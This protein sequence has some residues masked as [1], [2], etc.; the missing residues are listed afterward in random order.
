MKSSH[1]FPLVCIGI[2]MMCPFSTG[3]LCSSQKTEGA[4]QPALQQNK[5]AASFES[6]SFKTI[7]GDIAARVTPSIVS[8]ILTKIDTM[9]FNQ[10]PFFNFFGNDDSLDENP[11]NFFFGEP[12]SNHRHG[13]SKN[14]R[15]EK[16]E[17]REQ[18]IGSGVIVSQD[19]YILTNYH[20][21]SGASEIQVKLFDERSYEA[22]I[23]GADSLSDVAV[24]KIKEKV[25]NLPVATLGDDVKMRPGD[26][27]L[28]IGNPFSLTSTVTLG[29][30]SALH[31]E[32]D[33]NP[34]LY[35]NFIQTD[36]AI[37]PGN[38]GGA[39]VNIDGEVV[40]INTMIYSQTGGF[41]G[42][43]FA[44]PISMAK[45]V[46]DAILTKGKVVRGWIGISI[47]DLNEV[48][49]TTLNV[50]SR[51]GVLISDVFKGQPADKAG[52]K[53]GDVI[54]AIAGKNIENA[55]QLRNYVAELKPGSK[56]P[57]ALLRNGKEVV[58]QLTVEE[59]TEKVVSASG[60]EG[61]GQPGTREGSDKSE[62]RFGLTLSDLTQSLRSKYDL[63]DNV[64]GVLIIAVDRSLGDVRASL[65]EGDV[66]EQ[67][68]VRDKDYQTVESVRQFDEI[69]K[70]V[71]KGDSMLLVVVRKSASL[72]IGF[73]VH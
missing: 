58:L 62:A 53:R 34:N 11:F 65:R 71:K 61:E 23:V 72:F 67:V 1:L 57:A 38:S 12:F 42:I 24:L 35:Q 73:V 37:N 2:I 56:V 33:G 4:P 16:R 52:I 68:K 40:G 28:A 18:G 59:R 49:K 25:Q 7:F 13:M 70:T 48:M 27:A 8:V 55:N 19:G 54:T 69:A 36:A 30:V 10:N 50:G 3:L 5:Q 47:Q 64:K 31:R 32:V 66:I 63:A 43:G 44:I 6:P 45:T 9:T 46:M 60:K 22:K 14:P 26:W 29:I 20:V 15:P 17:Y 41:M 39:L 51:K 21:V